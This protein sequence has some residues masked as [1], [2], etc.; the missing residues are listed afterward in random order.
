MDEPQPPS[1]TPPEPP[2]P[3]PLPIVPASLLGTLLRVVPAVV[4]GAALV[5]AIAL[6]VVGRVDWW[7][8]YIPATVIAVIGG[9]AAIVVL[10]RA[11]GR[12]IDVAVTVIMA[13]AAVRIGV[14]AVGAIIAIT[15]LGSPMV[16]TALLV[17]GYYVVTLVAES[18]VFSRA[19]QAASPAST[20]T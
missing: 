7:A 20:D 5:V 1:S 3:K 16:P 19:V 14:S 13:A 10:S 6:A 12:P 8:G 18:V 11:A 2:K 17:C 4:I 9:I 15:A